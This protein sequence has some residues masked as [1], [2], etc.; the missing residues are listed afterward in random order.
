MGLGWWVPLLSLEVSCISGL[1]KWSTLDI[2]PWKETVHNRGKWSV[3]RN[4]VSRNSGLYTVQF[5]LFKSHLQVVLYAAQE[6]IANL[7]VN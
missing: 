5:Q 4:L 6:V 3:I 1:P 2:R 7:A